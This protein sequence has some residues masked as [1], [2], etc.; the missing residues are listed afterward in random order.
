MRPLADVVT[1]IIKI[2]P[3]DS[4]K[5][6]ELS[7]RL[8]CIVAKLSY[9][10]PECVADRWNEVAA[11]LNSCLPSPELFADKVP[12]VSKVARVFGDKEDYRKYL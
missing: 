4:S 11:I 3:D 12:W 7:R 6:E 8:A 5:K 2:V 1:A 9:T 10:A